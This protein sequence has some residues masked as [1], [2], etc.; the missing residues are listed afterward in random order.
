MRSSHYVAASAALLSLC[1]CASNPPLCPPPAVP[2]SVL[3]APL[4]PPGSFRDRLEM[5]IQQG[6]TS[7]QPSEPSPTMPTP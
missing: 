6:L 7:G 1:G 2:P 5:I 4:P 3:M